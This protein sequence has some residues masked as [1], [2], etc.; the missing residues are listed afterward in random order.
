MNVTATPSQQPLAADFLT[1][2]QEIERKKNNPSPA[3]IDDTPTKEVARI[4]DVA[5]FSEEAIDQLKQSAFDAAHAGEAQKLHF[6][7]DGVSLAK[8]TLGTTTAQGTTVNVTRTP[9]KNEAG[10]V[11]SSYSLSL[12]GKNGVN[13]NLDFTGDLSVTEDA[14]GATSVYFSSTNKTQK[15]D[16]S[17]SMTETDGNTLDKNANSV[18]INTSGSEVHT[19]E[20]NDT[21]LNFA[22]NATISTGSGNDTIYFSE[23]SQGNT[24]NSGDG[25]DTVHI[26]GRNQTVDLGGGNNTVHAGSMNGNQIT[27][28]DGNNTINVSGTIWNETQISLGDGNNTIQVNDVR[29]SSV[30]M[31]DGNNS[32]KIY[33]AGTNTSMSFGNG[34]NDVSIYQMGVNASMRLGNGDNLID[35]NSIQQNA[36]LALGNGNNAIKLYA[37][38]DDA[39]V[40]VGDGSNDVRVNEIRNNAQTNVGDGNNIAQIGRMDGSSLIKFG[41]GNNFAVF[42][43]HSDSASLTL[44]GGIAYDMNKLMPSDDQKD[45]YDTLESL[46]KD[47]EEQELPVTAAGED[48]TRFGTIQVG[49]GEQG[50]S[51]R[52]VVRPSVDKIV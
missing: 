39:K 18:I 33:Q 22:D 5:S 47:R 52:P 36:Q 34:N 44:G 11:S 25:N 8:E 6:G 29:N 49:T 26:K 42:G 27:A 23:L 30:E 51:I 1:K 37:V 31:G 24:V 40:K 50:S 45:I 48:G 9:S 3:L 12:A 4:G 16:A 20:G 21:V 41:T 14:D 28:A 15:Y 19:G 2:E 7:A 17:G 35:G 10:E 38:Q 46:R 32:A 43:K 13:V